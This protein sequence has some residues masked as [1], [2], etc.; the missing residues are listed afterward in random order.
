M[1]NKN[2]LEA[3]RKVK[4][5][6]KKRKFIQSIDLSISLRDVNLKDPSKRFRVEILLPHALNKKTN[7]CVIGDP[8]IIS[9]AETAGVKYTLNDDQIDQL[10]R[11]PNDAK[12]F[13]DTIDFF[14]ALPQMM[15]LVGKSLGRFLGPAGKMPSILPPNANISDYIIRYNRTCRIRLRQNPV[16]QCRVG[17]EDMEDKHIMNNIRSILTEIENR[18][19]QGSQNIRKTHIKST[20]GPVIEIGG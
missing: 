14:L 19:D 20:M 7:I 17:T 18:L 8:D 5:S 15:A 2:I 3:V 12:S 16:I 4:S 13:I 10:A 6:S 1:E 11:N 9:R